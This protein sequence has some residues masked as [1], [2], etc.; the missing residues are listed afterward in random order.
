[1]S[2]TDGSPPETDVR[3]GK[4]SASGAER[5]MNCPGSFRFEAQFPEEEVQDW[6]RDG[7]KIA[8]ALEHDTVD[9]LEEDLRPIAEQLQEMEETA[10][11]KWKTR[12][13]I[14]ATPEPWREIRFW[15]RH[16]FQPIVSAQIDVGYY[17]PFT[18]QL[19]I[20]DD[21]S[22][23]LDPTSAARN[24]QLMCQAACIYE[25][26]EF[27]GVTVAIAHA[28]FRTNYT[29]AFYDAGQIVAAREQIR[30]SIVRG[31]DAH[32]PR[33][34]GDWCRYCRAKAHCREAHAWLLVDLITFNDAPCGQCGT[35]F[36][37]IQ[38]NAEIPVSVGA[39]SDEAA[40]V[41]LGKIG[42]GGKLWDAIKARLKALTN[43]QLQQLGL[44]RVPN[45]ETRTITNRDRAKELLL[46][47]L[48]EV[49]FDAA[50]PPN[51]GMIEKAVQT[52]AGLKAKESKAAVNR[53]L[54]P[55]IDRKPKSPTLKV[56]K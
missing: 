28:R 55:V 37:L 33:Y 21:K 23:F 10:L 8:D 15:M 30:N 52:H 2:Q 1:M 40:A 9:E 14:E 36:S 29:E 43:E 7:T 17:D 3:E 41:V 5:W 16:E 20:I 42:I 54:D 38:G 44:E 31:D 12:H 39:L 13:G 46:P 19:L 47:Y 34:P 45:G 26:T 22:G 49:E 6:T 11:L 27:A 56:I 24:F 53:V 51:L 18:R 48:T 25:E 4:R 32:A 35:H 50:C